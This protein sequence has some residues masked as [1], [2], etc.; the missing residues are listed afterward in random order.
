M[1][2]RRDAGATAKATLARP[3]NEMFAGRLKL[4]QNRRN[5]W[6][7][8]CELPE[9]CDSCRGFRCFPLC[10]CNWLVGAECAFGTSSNQASA[11]ADHR[12]AVAGCYACRSGGESGRVAGRK[13]VS[14]CD[15]LL[16]RGAE[17]EFAFGGV[18][19]QNRDH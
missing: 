7:W 19:E 11:V 12:S 2:R 17:Q 15:G 5:Y 8:P 6:G 1:G 13:I 16:S 3:K 4:C 14:G 9:S 10:H 18:A